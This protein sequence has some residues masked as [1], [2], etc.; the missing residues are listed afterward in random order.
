MAAI[1]GMLLDASTSGEDAGKDLLQAYARHLIE[2]DAAIPDM[3]PDDADALLEATGTVLVTYS[4]RARF[5]LDWVVPRWLNRHA[6]DLR[7]STA[8]VIAG[9]VAAAPFPDIHEMEFSDRL[10]RLP[11][12]AQGAGVAA[13]ESGAA[14]VATGLHGTA[15]YTA[16]PTGEALLFAAR[17]VARHALAARR[18]LTMRREYRDMPA[19]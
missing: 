9:A 16:G 11:Y 15:K 4:Q 8:S 5:D 14:F 19:F 3:R 2:G 6:F 18:R 13:L 10:H 12:E 1:G 7:M 17:R